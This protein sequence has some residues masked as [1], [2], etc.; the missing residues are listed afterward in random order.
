MTD[1]ELLKISLLLR[2]PIVWDPVPPWLRLKPEQL[3]KFNEL[4]NRW[5][6]KLAEIDQQKVQELGKITGL[7]L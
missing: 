3:Q 1:K 2:K 7:G 6:A 5:N 4:Q